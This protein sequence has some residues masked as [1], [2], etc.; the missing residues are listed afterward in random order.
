MTAKSGARN[1]ETLPHNIGTRTSTD[2]AKATKTINAGST[3]SQS[4]EDTQMFTR[5]ELTP[6]PLT[7]P[8]FVRKRTP[9]LITE[10]ARHVELRQKQHRQRLYLAAGVKRRNNHDDSQDVLA[11]YEAIRQYRESE[12]V[13][14]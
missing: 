1:A 10:T 2:A 14:A 7:V 6:D 4:R 3:A 11:A 9:L 8:I 12:P 13:I 5:V